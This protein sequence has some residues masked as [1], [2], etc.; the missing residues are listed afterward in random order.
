MNRVL[1]RCTKSND[2]YTN[3]IFAEILSEV[4]VED[5]FDELKMVAKIIHH[6]FESRNRFAEKASG[7]FK[8]LD[9]LKQDSRVLKEKVSATAEVFVRNK[10]DGSLVIMQCPDKKTLKCHSE[11][12]VELMEVRY[13]IFL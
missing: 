11:L 13:Y 5:N 7:I 6:F 3:S 12:L 1:K 2:G 4:Y 9:I 8:Q 10:S